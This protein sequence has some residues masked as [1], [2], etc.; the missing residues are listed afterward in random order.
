M[1]TTDPESEPLVGTLAR[2][3]VAIK[4]HA[5]GERSYHKRKLLGENTQEI[6]PA[7]D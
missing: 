2:Q 7:Q 5:E 1:V 6:L 4:D 3:A